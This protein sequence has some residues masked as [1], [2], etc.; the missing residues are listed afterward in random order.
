MFTD[1]DTDDD[2]C[3]A[4]GRSEMME[5]SKKLSLL[6]A[7]TGRHFVHLLV[8]IYI[9]MVMTNSANSDNGQSVVIASI[10]CLIL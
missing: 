9:C 8:C 2:A 4:C 10:T 1:D 5:H 6:K 3:L 7:L